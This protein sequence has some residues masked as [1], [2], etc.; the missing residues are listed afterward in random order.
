MK[1]FLRQPCVEV[2]VASVR[3]SAPREAGALMLVS[4]SGLWGTIGGGQLEYMA[5]EQARALLRE[6]GA[7]QMD[8]PLGPEIGQ[9]CGGRVNVSL[10]VVDEARAEALLHEEEARVA[11]LPL[12]KL[13]GAGHVGRALARAFALLPVRCV[14]VDGRADELARAGDMPKRLSVLPEAEVAGADVVVIA[15]HEHALDYMLAAEALKGDARY[16]GMIGSKT[17]RAR[18]E[19][20]YEGDASALVCPMAADMKGDRRP[21]VIAAFVAAEVMAVLAKE[22]TYEAH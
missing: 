19:S 21:E 7:G 3:G 13:F 22:M 18:F 17:K 20:W 2:R 16:V 14:L 9:C 10:R 15:T 4:E 6:G 8:V 11:A 1:A 12:V 5:I